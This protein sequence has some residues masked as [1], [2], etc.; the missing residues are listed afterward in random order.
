VTT[1]APAR[2]LLVDDE[3]SVLF[4]LEAVLKK[5][6][7]AV[8]AV[9]SGLEA[10]RAIREHSFDLLLSDLRID[11]VDGLTL[12][13]AA[14]KRDP[15]T[16]SILLTGYAS[17]ESA[18]QALR[19]GAFNYL[20]KPCNID[21]MKLT[22]ARGLEK[23]RLAEA[24]RER[25]VE[26]EEANETIRSFTAQLEDKVKTATAEL[27]E[28]VRDLQESRGRLDAVID[29][30]KDGLVVYDREGRA[31]RANTFMLSLFGLS[32]TAVLGRTAEAKERGLVLSSTNED[33]LAAAAV[34]ELDSPRTRFVRRV[35]SP[36]IGQGAPLSGL[37]VVYQD[38]TDQKEVEQLKDDFLSIASHE[39][40]TPLTSIMGYTQLLSRRLAPEAR[41]AGSDDAIEVIEN[42]CRRMK[43]LV[44]DLL[45]VSRIER[46]TLG[47]AH[48]KVDLLCLTENVVRK[49][50]ATSPEHKFMLDKPKAD[51]PVWCDED[52]LEQLLSNLV[53]NAVKYS[54]DGG[55]VEVRVTRNGE[56][57]EVAVRDWGIG[58]PADQQPRIFSRF[59]QA[60]SVVRSRRF[61]GMGLG[62]FISK[63]IVDEMGGSI[64]VDSTVGKGST[65]RFTLPIH[66]G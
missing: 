39:L 15:E 58:I 53:S 64:R 51:V 48:S 22:I 25:V 36:V 33:Q 20:L 50:E 40:K 34:F 10:L 61:G 41:R 12:L 42:Q 17:L 38:I 28:R 55:K 19:Y 3:E 23:K 16:V 9:N 26:L 18:V 35:I 46:G 8:T 62:L 31:L 11:D 65:F 2:I 27:A 5:E 45:D 52:R 47:T 29:S 6:G 14:Q 54:P 60:E 57:A 24:L 21:E 63:A 66:L 7:Y 4:T 1:E 13:A 56:T 49:F 44:E 43:R 37:V 30:M 32:S 59:Y